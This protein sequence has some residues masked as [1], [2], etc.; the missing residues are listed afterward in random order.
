MKGGAEEDEAVID[1]DEEAVECTDEM[2]RSGS[3]DADQE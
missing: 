1:Q 3:I 2:I